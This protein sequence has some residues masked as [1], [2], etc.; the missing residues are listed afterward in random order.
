MPIRIK[1][2]D[3]PRDRAHPIEA[4]GFSAPLADD[5]AACHAE[6]KPKSRMLCGSSELLLGRQERRKE[7]RC[8]K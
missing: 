8:L 6:R 3:E 4:K 2:R 1:W 7:D 5:P